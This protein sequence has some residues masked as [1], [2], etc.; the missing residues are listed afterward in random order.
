MKKFLFVFLLILTCQNLTFA[1]TSEA[2][3]SVTLIQDSEI[4]AEQVFEI[5]ENK[6]VVNVLKQPLNENS[7]QKIIMKKNWFVLNI[8]INGKVKVQPLTSTYEVE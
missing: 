5:R 4:V 7:K 2:E 8:G 6:V 1:E 3:N